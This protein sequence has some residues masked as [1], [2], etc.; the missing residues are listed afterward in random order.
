MKSLENFFSIRFLIFAACMFGAIYCSSLVSIYNALQKYYICEIALFFAPGI[1]IITVYVIIAHMVVYFCPLSVRRFM[2]RVS[3]QYVPL[4]SIC[5]CL[6]IVLCM[7]FMFFAAHLF[8]CIIATIMFVSSII[9]LVVDAF[10]FVICVLGVA[11]MKNIY[12]PLMSLHLLFLEFMIVCSQLFWYLSFRHFVWRDYRPYGKKWRRDFAD[13][14]ICMRQWFGV[15]HRL[16]ALCDDEYYIVN[17]CAQIIVTTD[18]SEIW[19][20]RFM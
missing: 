15:P 3:F 6:L 11:K 17:D 8:L 10:T 19:E 5:E 18:D 12:H 7:V 20:G 13:S 4:P 16:P 2:Y 9:F 1:A 14:F